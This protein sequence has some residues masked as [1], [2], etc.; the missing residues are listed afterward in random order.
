MG[1][2]GRTSTSSSSDHPVDR[3]GVHREP[4]YYVGS[5]MQNPSLA[6]SPEGP[7][8][9]PPTL[10]FGDSLEGSSGTP[11]TCGGERPSPTERGLPPLP[12]RSDRY[13]IFFTSDSRRRQENT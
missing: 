10:H 8:P 3:S 6:T 1:S 4:R 2:D 9:R 12:S 7:T 5:S 11:S 13:R